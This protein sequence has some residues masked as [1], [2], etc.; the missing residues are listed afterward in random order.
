MASRPM[1][2][3]DRVLA[4]DG[5]E[6][7][8]EKEDNT[9]LYRVLGDTKIPVSK[10]MGLL[11]QSRRDQGL[12][13]REDA[14]TRWDEAI[15]YYENDQINH[16]GSKDNS[17]GNS[18][19]SRRLNNEW[20]ETENVVFA[21]ASIMI[22]MLYEKNPTLTVTPNTDANEPLAHA[23][24]ALGN[25]L[26]S[27]KTA[28]GVGL[29]AKMRRTV[30][31]TLLTNAGWLKINWVGKEN[32]SEQAV[33]ELQQLGEQ[34]AEAKTQKEIKEIEGKIAALEERIDLISPAGPAI[35][36]RA[37]HNI[38]TDPTAD[39]ADGVDGN[40]M[41]EWDYLPTDYINAVYARKQGQQFVS[42]Y[43]PTHIMMSK[44]QTAQGVEDEVNQFKLIPDDGEVKP[45]AY[46]YKT[47]A[48]LKSASMTK[49][50][51]VWD[52]T[53]RRVYMFADN[54]WKWPIWVWDDPLR[55]PRFFP[56]FKLSF[57][58]GTSSQ[59]SKGEVTYYL[60]QQ[61]AINEINDEVRRG[62]HWAKRNL[63][64]NKNAIS[65]EDVES[66]LKG[67]DGTAR[68]VKL[69][70]G[71][72]LDKAIMSITPPS[73]KF[74]ELFNSDSKFAAINR[75]T[76]INDAMRGAQYKTNTTNKAINEYQSNVDIRIGERVDLIEDFIADVMWNVLMLCLMNWEMQ[77]V[78]T[79]IGQ[80][81]AGWRRI[82]NNAEFNT[83][84]NFRV[85]SGSI[86]KPNSREMKQQAVQLGQVLGQFASASPA[87][88]VVMLKM[89]ERAFEGQVV[90]SD[91][92]WAQ[93]NET[94]M[95]ALTKAGNGPGGEEAP[96]DPNAEP[97]QTDEQLKEQVRAQIEALPP[98]GQEMLQELVS[99][100]VPPAEALKQVQQ[101]V[102]QATS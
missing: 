24:T 93:I 62:R 18:V 37:P 63:F 52:K 50:W 38:V 96:P 3:I 32:S 66:V 42:V 30:L 34:L 23:V 8:Q 17:S 49:V 64:Y 55:L 73:L 46:G 58:E 16:R 6:V 75:I 86:G 87:I 61:D 40:W 2:G 90:I 31:M 94:M 39:E 57:H 88:V 27:M 99:Q 20:T 101:Q 10:K 47:E 44:D 9:P 19:Y 81:A 45:K 11:W 79:L 7:E 76:G 4:N 14:Q 15:R 54:Y 67:P 1:E 65:Q 21:N 68:G 69:E 77:D 59:N 26:I 60:D 91:S 70:E 80:D 84:I 33:Q 100:G 74:P 25:K 36:V 43:E 92:E 56:Y 71:Q 83:A 48:Q 98:Q 28:P 5:I 22:P 72:T 53:T 95:M 102:Q 41:M 85:E 89:F 78:Q 13:S 35:T 12:C 29:K 82:T 97:A 51:W